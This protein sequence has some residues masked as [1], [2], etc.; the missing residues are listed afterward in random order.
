MT[1]VVPA[2]S[3][4]R[5]TGKLRNLRDV[6][7]VLNVIR[8]M[9][10]PTMYWFYNAYAFEMR[11]ALKAKSADHAAPV[12][13]ILELEDWPLARKRGLNPKPLLDYG[14]WLSARS[15]RIMT[16]AFVVNSVLAQK[17]GGYV[18]EV[19]LL[20]GVVPETLASL[21]YSKPPFVGERSGLSIGFFGGLSPEKGADVV[22]R[23]APRL[24]PRYVLHVT[25]TGPLEPAF[26][27]YAEKWP[28]RMQFHGSVGEAALYHLIGQTDIIVNPHVELAR[29][30]N[31]V[32]PFK[33]VEAIAGGRLLISTGLP[34]TGLEDLLGGVLFVS[35]TEEGFLTA[36]LGARAWY[37]ERRSVIAASANEA[38]ARFGEAA[39]LN[40][41][42]RIVSEAQESG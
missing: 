6:P 8:A 27:E 4:S 29:L 7:E 32:F 42:A 34:T 33:V 11:F 36:I 2:Q 30:G 26:V 41:L 35:R 20:P 28:E 24:P 23:L 17:L 25:G 1:E 39:L 38:V 15:A 31:G 9:G 14:Y 12:P 21:P 13:M 10:V 40:R 5:R 22:L 16:H 19:A 37:E 3:R 18:D